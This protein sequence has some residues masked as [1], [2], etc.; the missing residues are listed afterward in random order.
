MLLHMYDNLPCKWRKTL[1]VRAK[2][3]ASAI[4]IECLYRIPEQGRQDW[5]AS[6]CRN[7]KMSHTDYQH[8]ISLALAALGISAD[9]VARTGLPLFMEAREL[10]LAET[11]ADG[12]A[13]HLVPPAAQAWRA[14]KLEAQRDGIVLE[15]VSAFRGLQAQSA[16]IR[17]KLERRMPL[18]KIFT[19]SA[20]PGYSEHHTGRAVDINTPG[21]VPREEP[22]EDTEAFRW[23]VAH[24]GSFCFIMSYP[25]GNPLG[26]S[27][28]PW[29]WYFTG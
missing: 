4:T 29:H 8:R 10:A 7:R 27:Y 18:E 5:P 2:S 22:F 6:R 26:F 11:D 19:L 13:H 16:I 1:A 14:M 24:A 21:C 17:D 25:R 28:E 9:D 3:G 23:L 12:S 20:P 15:I